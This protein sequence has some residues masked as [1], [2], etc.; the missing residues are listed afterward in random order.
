MNNSNTRKFEEEILYQINLS[1]HEETPFCR[2]D[3]ILKVR[4]FIL[5]K[6]ENR[7]QIFKSFI[8][9]EICG[10]NIPNLSIHL[11]PL[12]LNWLVNSIKSS[13][14]DKQHYPYHENSKNILKFEP[15]YNS[16]SI[17]I[18]KEDE[19]SKG[20]ILLHD[21]EYSKLIEVYE[22]TFKDIIDKA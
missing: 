10:E 3:K 22:S 13:S 21:H 11:S 5:R 4:K 15:F 8:Q 19:N 20:Y 17:R 2:I 12:E 14:N 9:I 16:S 7:F 18:E 6:F 1:E